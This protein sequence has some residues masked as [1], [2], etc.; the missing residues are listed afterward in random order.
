M[1][2]AKARTDRIVEVESSIGRNHKNF[3]CTEWVSGWELQFAMINPSFIRTISQ[4]EDQKV[5]GE[6]IIVF[7]H[8]VKVTEFSPT[9]NYLKLFLKPLS[10]TAALGHFSLQLLK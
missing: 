7:W 4:S 9:R 6:N 8:C 2:V 3:R 5:P 1:V 10:S